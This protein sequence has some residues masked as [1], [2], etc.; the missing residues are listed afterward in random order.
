MDPERHET[1]ERIPWETLE[2]TTGD[3]QWL[4]YAVA[5]AVVLGALAYS[6]MRNQP[7]AGLPQDAAPPV[8]TTAPATIPPPTS[9]PEAPSSTVASPVVV[10]EADLYAVDPERLVDQATGHAEW[11]ALEY[12]A[13]DGSEQS[14][15]LLA[16]LLPRGVPLPEAPEGTQVFVDWVRTRSV[17][18]TGPM[19]FEVEVLVRSLVGDGDGGFA[20]QAPSVVAV[21]VEVGEDGST[22]VTGVPSMAPVPPV[23]PAELSLTQPPDDV[24]AGVEGDVVGGLQRADGGW[25][26]IVMS[27]GPDGVRRPMTVSP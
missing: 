12:T 25:D 22:V 17:T 5:G 1:Y 20:R 14:R 11:V 10:A 9:A 19:S 3:R 2:K 24:L 27:E 16:D 8:A 18:Q 6:F 23:V 21:Q 15:A 13:V 26:V 4:V 7:T